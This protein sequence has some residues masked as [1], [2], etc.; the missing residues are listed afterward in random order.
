MN[1]INLNVNVLIY[2]IVWYNTGGGV[3]DEKRK[4]YTGKL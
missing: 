1:L 4:N 2:K 3:E